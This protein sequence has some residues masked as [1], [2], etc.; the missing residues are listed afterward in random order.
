[1]AFKKEVYKMKNNNSKSQI[2]SYSKKQLKEV[3]KMN[4]KNIFIL[5]L[6]A[7]TLLLFANS[8]FAID[9]Y[10]EGHLTISGTVDYSN[11]KVIMNQSFYKQTITINSGGVFNLTNSNITTNYNEYNIIVNSG[12]TLIIDNTRF[13]KLDEGITINSGAIV[14]YFGDVVFTSSNTG[15]P[16][17]LYNDFTITG[18]I[19]TDKGFIEIKESNIVINGNGF[20]LYGDNAALF[21]GLYAQNVNNIEIKNFNDIKNFFFGVRLHNTHSSKININTIYDNS[22]GIQ[23]TG[24]TSTEN[25]ILLNNNL[26]GNFESQIQDGTGSSR[27]NYLIYNNT[28]GEIKWT[29]TN[30]GVSSAENDYLI[31]GSTIKINPNNIS[32]NKDFVTS[33]LKGSANVTIHNNP[34]AGFEE[35]AVVAR[36]THALCSD[37]TSPE[38]NPNPSL[39]TSSAMFT[40]SQLSGSDLTY[41]SMSNANLTAVKINQTVHLASQGGLLQFYFNITNVGNVTFNSSVMDILPIGLNYVNASIAP[42]NVVGNAVLGTNV[43]WHINDTFEKDGFFEVY[44]NA[45]VVNNTL[46]SECWNLTNTIIASA[47]VNS[48]TSATFDDSFWFNV[49][50]ASV[51]QSPALII[52][53]TTFTAS[54]GGIVEYVVN[55][56]NNGN[57]TLK[58]VYVNSSVN[59]QLSYSSSSMVPV[60][61]IVL[62]K[63]NGTEWV[64]WHLGNLTSG[65]T[66]VFYINYTVDYNITQCV[67]TT[68]T[69]DVVGVPF[70]GDNVTAIYGVDVTVCN[71]SLDPEPS[72][73]INATAYLAS[74]GGIVEYIINVTNN[75]NVTLNVTINSSVDK[76]LTYTSHS[77]DNNSIITQ[78]VIGSTWI[79]WDLL[80]VSSGVTETFYINF[81]VNPFITDA[82][83]LTNN[84]IN[85]TGYPYNGD[86]VNVV[87]GIEVNV[88]NASLEENASLIVNATSYL[89]SQ[90]GIVEYIVNVSNN[91]NVTFKE[92]YV[93]SSVDVQLT[94]NNS[95][96]DLNSTFEQISNNTRWVAWNLSALYSGE[97]DEFFINFTVDPFLID[98]CV[99]TTLTIN[100][101]GVP[102]NGDNVYVTYDILVMVCNAS[103]E[104]NASL[105]VNAT[106]HVASQGGIVEY[107][108][109][110]SNNGNVTFKEIYVNSSVSPQLSYN[111]SD[112]D[113]VSN[114]TNITNSTKWVAWDLSELESGEVD[115]FFINFTVD[116]GLIGCVNTTLTINVTGVPYN[117]DNVTVEYELNVTVCEANV[118]NALEVNQSFALAS[119]GGIVAYIINVTNNGEVP[120]NVTIL[121]TLP[122]G[123]TYSNASIEPNSTNASTREIT[124][125][126]RLE[127]DESFI[128]NMNATVDDF[129]TLACL[130]LT[131]ILNVTGVPDNGDNVTTN[132]SITTKVCAAAIEVQRSATEVA[133]DLNQHA[134]FILTVNNTGFV[135]LSN[136]TLNYVL[137]SGLELVLFDP[138]QDSNI[139]NVYTWNIGNLSFKN[140]T[141]LTVTMKGNTYGRF[142]N[143]INVTADVPNGDSVS[144]LTSVVVNVRKPGSRGGGGSNWNNNTAPI[145]V[146]SIIPEK[147]PLVAYDYSYS[148]S[149]GV[150]QPQEPISQETGEEELRAGPREESLEHMQTWV[151]KTKATMDN[152]FKN[153]PYAGYLIPL[154]VML[155]LVLFIVFMKPKKLKK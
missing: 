138:V 6:M 126:K 8:V 89:A 108:V 66:E 151:E 18:N 119:Q 4:H 46:I 28:N 127:K 152:F 53:V 153:Q 79:L 73:M 27:I 132:N 37:I 135:N 59:Q 44:V 71:A 3:P 23:L 31:L 52:N 33:Y 54:Q 9:H 36:N 146:D 104:E 14:P 109:N 148:Y 140:S 144:H 88:C 17:K 147:R 65:S 115:I 130:N 39:N 11:A 83:V 2:S 129:T 60:N 93:N 111:N 64:L 16:I 139:S 70:N 134:T 50:N 78:N 12:G 40:V 123:L 61:S 62:N 85:V 124:W 26:Y 82:C 34:F 19:N 7:I 125:L 96:W 13:N 94:Y 106:S 41:Y 142:S 114:F 47:I 45:T 29:N 100:V 128:I 15:Y 74:Q 38:C 141:T 154:V 24:A 20:S 72:I 121:D 101:T 32:V 103:L 149:G 99:D 43:T 21:G 91:G 48:T 56:T 92:I 118:T 90:G 110:V 155:T 107:I 131:N 80:N 77:F 143:T 145:F 49:C 30:L 68:N 55:V 58:D 84:T 35:Y 137:N 69:I 102:Y 105:I 112:W 22:Y 25:N 113:L 117:G 1:M 116:E 42:S 95:A 150:S 10:I 81:T 98:E 136:V 120:L 133:V 5:S 86:L 75:G 76:Q 87:N 63:T 67:D 51:L 57:V 122:A 97:V